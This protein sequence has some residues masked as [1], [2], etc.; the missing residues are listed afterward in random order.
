MTLTVEKQTEVLTTNLELSVCAILPS[1][2]VIVQKK[3]LVK[4]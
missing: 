1:D 2:F 3:M 4:F